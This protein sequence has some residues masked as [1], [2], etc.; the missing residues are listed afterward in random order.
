MK[1]AS[2]CRSQLNAE[3]LVYLREVNVPFTEGTSM[4]K[5]LEVP[6]Q[7]RAW[8]IAGLPT[9]SVSIENGALTSAAVFKIK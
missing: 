5:T 4:I 9:D 3:W 8:A 7:S 2:L 1:K 6:V